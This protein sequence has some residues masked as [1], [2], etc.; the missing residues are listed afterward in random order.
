[1]KELLISN[2]VLY[3]PPKSNIL[4]STRISNNGNI[5]LRD[6]LVITAEEENG[7]GRVYPIELWEREISKF[8]Q[9][10]KNSTTECIGELDH[11]DSSV[12]NLRNGSHIVRKLNWE[13]KRVLADIEI[14][15]DIGPKGNE[16]GRILGSYLLNGLAIGFSTRGMGSL[17]E[18]NGRMKVQDDFDFVTIDAVSNPSNQG[19]WGVLKEGMNEDNKRDKYY[20]INKII[21]QILCSNGSCPII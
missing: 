15:C 18:E 2:P 7:N 16:A 17:K 19:S 10:I 1:M 5:L 12:I 14:L 13:G 11:P 4:E 8:Q 3:S 21:T 6:V 9:K 20:N